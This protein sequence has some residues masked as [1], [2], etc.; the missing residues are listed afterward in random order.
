MDIL[1]NKLLILL[2]HLKNMFYL[3][4]FI[5]YTHIEVYKIPQSLELPC[6]GIFYFKEIQ[7]YSKTDTSAAI[8]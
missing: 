8:S 3:N 4:L 2:F 5:I 6:F 7:I 1:L